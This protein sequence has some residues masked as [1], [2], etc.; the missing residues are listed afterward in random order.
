MRWVR[1]RGASVGIFLKTLLNRQVFIWSRFNFL[2]PGL[3]TPAGSNTRVSQTHH[4]KY[5]FR[6]LFTFLFSSFD[7]LPNF[8]PLFSPT[9]LFLFFF[10]TLETQCNQIRQKF[11]T[12]EFLRVFGR[13]LKVYLVFGKMFNLLWQIFMLTAK[14]TAF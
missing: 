10:Q 7:C 13:F 1:I 3:L 12:S 14:F 8:S 2:W 9:C 11:T 5:D 6:R 4:V